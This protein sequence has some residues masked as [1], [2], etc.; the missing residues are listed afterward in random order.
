MSNP[1]SHNKS[2]SSQR[3]KPTCAC[4]KKCI[5]ECIVGMENS[6][7]CCKCFHKDRYLP[8]MKLK[9]KGSMQAQVS[10]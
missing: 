6:F 7:G 8:N 1:K 10:S 5:G 4:G 9:D 2:T 3:K